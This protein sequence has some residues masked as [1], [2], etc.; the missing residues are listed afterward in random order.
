MANL[1]TN[2][3]I[4]HGLMAVVYR[5]HWHEHYQAV[6][7]WVPEEKEVLD[8]CCADGALAAYLPASNHYH[9]LDYSPALVQAGQRR[10]RDVQQF[11][12]RS[13]ILPE[14]DI[15]CIQVS[16]FQFYPETAG[17][18]AKLYAAARE[19]LIVSESVFSL[20]QSRWKWIA[21]I[22]GHGTQMPGMKDHRFRFSPETLAKLFEPYQDKLRHHGPV[23]GG[24]DWIY[25][26]DK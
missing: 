21:D 10:G 16:L 7:Q 17:I 24:R 6:A 25:V 18:L 5:R 15:V 22:V 1:Y 20:T 4:Y 8:V 11:D 19:R 12:L 13:G 23:C 2:R 3:W 14:A 9:G 26:V